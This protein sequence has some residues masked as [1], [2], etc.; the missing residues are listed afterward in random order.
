MESLYRTRYS[1]SDIA[2]IVNRESYS[3]WK[4]GL[5][6]R[7]RLRKKSKDR[8]ADMEEDLARVTLLAHA[9]AQACLKKGVLTQ[10][11]LSSMMNELDMA[12]GKADGKMTTPSKRKKKR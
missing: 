9:L 1:Q 7:K 12:D 3:R 5:R 2:E 4:R 8:F 6:R 11:A 10:N